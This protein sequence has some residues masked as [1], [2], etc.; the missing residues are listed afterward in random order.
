MGLFANRV[1]ID[2]F[3][4]KLEWLKATAAYAT[5]SPEAR[6]NAFFLSLFIEAAEAVARDKEH[7]AGPPSPTDK[8]GGAF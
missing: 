7:N 6:Q 1:F 3:A 4:R 8:R 5:K 2:A